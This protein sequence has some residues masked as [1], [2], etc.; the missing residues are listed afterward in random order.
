M[1]EEKKQ[2]EINLLELM[3]MF[4]RG[5]KKCGLNLINLLGNTLRLLYRNKVLTCVIL[6]LSIAFGFSMGRSDNRVFRAEAMAIL[7]GSLAQTVK[8]VSRQLENASHLSDFTSLSSRLSLPYE[9]ANNIISIESFYVID[10]LNDSTPDMVDFRHRHSW[11]DTLNVRMPNRL[12]FRVRTRDVS[13]LPVFEQA[14]L[15][16]FNTNTQLLGEFNV[17]KNNLAQEIQILNSELIR[18]DSLADFSYF[19]DISGGQQID[20]RWNTLFVGEQRTQMLHRYFSIVQNRKTVRELE[21]VSFTAPV[22]LPTGFIVNPHPE[23]GRIGY[24]LNY[25]LIGLAIAISLSLFIE[26]RKR[27]FNY[28][29]SKD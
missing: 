26:H 13:Q 7:N 27:I 1:K 10:F 11:T 3:Q 21:F 19:R 29:S 18:L 9:I 4:F 12:F 14:F 20:F 22:V 8:E 15:N 5:L 28:L 25:F 23:R 16:Y 2:N 6:A 24:M 17:R